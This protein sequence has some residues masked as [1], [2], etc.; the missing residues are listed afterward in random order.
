MAKIKR[1]KGDATQ[2]AGPWPA[3]VAHVC[4]DIGAWGRGFVLAVSRAWP[5]AEQSYRAW[6]RS[7][8]EGGFALGATQFVRISD[9]L[10]V[11]NMVA[12]HGIR[13]SKAGPPIRYEALSTC[14]GSVRDRALEIGA[15]V[16]LP[17]IGA[18]LAGGDW[19]KIR[20]IILS[21]LC[22][23]GV[24]VTLYEYTP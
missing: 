18:G 13:A 1:I 5:E 16:H 8:E 12:Q 9:D 7:G 14:L 11:A 20:R 2:L 23:H 4:N 6:H 19:G 21:E 22:K 15:G 10:L 24:K 17:R 3:I